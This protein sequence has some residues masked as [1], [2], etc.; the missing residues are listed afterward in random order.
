[1]IQGSRD[2]AF[3][4]SSTMCHSHGFARPG[5]WALPNISP[6]K[7]WGKNT[8][9]FYWPLRLG[10]KAC[11]SG[12]DGS[13]ESRGAGARRHRRRGFGV[14]EMTGSGTPARLQ[15]KVAWQCPSLCLAF[16]CVYICRERD[17]CR[18]TVSDAIDWEGN[19]CICQ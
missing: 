8:C 13:Q 4:P 9:G 2:D 5:F 6:W 14:V 12:E 1:M 19:L 18:E 3:I 7:F 11:S 10:G 17:F 16:V 15:V